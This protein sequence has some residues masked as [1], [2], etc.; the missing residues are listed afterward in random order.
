MALDKIHLRKLL[1]ILFLNT[2]MRQSAIR[3]DIREEI[4]KQSRSSDSGG[5]FYVPFWT[6]ARRHVFG[7]EDLHISVQ[8]RIA[9]NS[10]RKRLYPKLCSGFLLW[11]N[12]RRRWTNEPFQPGT[13]LKANVHFPEIDAVVKIDNI[14]SVRDGMGI[15]HVIYPYFAENPNL[16]A[17]AA[18]L[19]LWL[20]LRAFPSVPKNEI[21]ILDIIR[22]Q[23]F[24]IDRHPLRGNEEEIFHQLYIQL[25]QDRDKVI[26][27]YY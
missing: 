8:A 9:A 21:R 27:K 13:S 22:G 11:W 7:F 15:E 1:K 6:D 10:A 26:D 24:S 18:R 14:L 4:A 25:L 3:A 19:G 5:D 16:S 20:L 12:E 17:D 23:T 2:S